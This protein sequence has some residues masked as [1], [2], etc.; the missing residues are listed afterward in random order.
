MEVASAIGAG[1]SGADASA[2]PPESDVVSKD[3][4]IKK[5]NRNSEKSCFLRN[6]F[7]FIYFIQHYLCNDFD[8]SQTGRY[9]ML[10]MFRKIFRRS[11]IQEMRF[12]HRNTRLFSTSTKEQAFYFLDQPCNFILFRRYNFGQYPQFESKDIHE[13]RIHHYRIK[14]LGFFMSNEFGGT[15]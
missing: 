13:R 12:E 10:R 2:P 3:L 15:E 8:C 9:R 7:S 1:A 5:R 11:K 6:G 14:V 4:P